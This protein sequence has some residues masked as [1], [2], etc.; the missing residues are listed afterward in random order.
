MYMGWLRMEK[1][2][3]WVQEQ[4]FRIGKL[5]GKSLEREVNDRTVHLGKGQR[6]F[7]TGVLY[8]YGRRVCRLQSGRAPK[9]EAFHFICYSISTRRSMHFYIL[10]CFRA[11]AR[12]YCISR[13]NS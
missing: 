2:L 9:D 11:Q 5:K 7:E 3:E 12:G 13:V 8:I 1:T 6:G 10:F 4:D